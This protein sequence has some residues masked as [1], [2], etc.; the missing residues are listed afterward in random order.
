[1][2]H[3]RHT[4]YRKAQEEEYLTRSSNLEQLA[5]RNTAGYY[6][7]GSIT[8][9]YSVECVAFLSRLRDLTDLTGELQQGIVHP[10]HL[11]V[12]LSALFLLPGLPQWPDP[13]VVRRGRVYK[14]K[15]LLIV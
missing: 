12:S 10:T 7:Y 1:M 15:P 4:V 8:I 14:P 13:Q 11:S 6:L 5:E 3:T 2:C 9:L